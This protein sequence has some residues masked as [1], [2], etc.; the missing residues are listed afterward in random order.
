[1]PTIWSVLGVITHVI[2][3]VVFHMRV[4]RLDRGGQCI[5]RSTIVSLLKAM[6]SPSQWPTISGIYHTSK[7]MA[8]REFDSQLKDKEE[9]LQYSIIPESRW[10]TFLAWFLS[11]FIIFHIILGTYILSST[12]FI[13]PKDALGVLARYVLSVIIYRVI[14]VYEL[15]VQ[16]VDAKFDTSSHYEGFRD[17]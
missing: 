4:R 11:V 12:N 16:R 15:A 1:M 5:R 8:Y 6:M 14:V 13:G 17:I 7:R 10:F 3:A 9:S 2:G